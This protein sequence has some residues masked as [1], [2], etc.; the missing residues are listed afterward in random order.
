MRF[1]QARPQTTVTTESRW[2]DAHDPPGEAEAASFG[3]SEAEAS[4]QE[5]TKPFAPT[6]KSTD[7]L[8]SNMGLLFP[9]LSGEEGPPPPAVDASK[10]WLTPFRLLLF[11]GGG[12]A[13]GLAMLML[14]LLM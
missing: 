11:A 7:P 2:A 5:A 12:A 14:W 8:I 6:E 9:H 10:S 13:A 1:G 3:S 4:V